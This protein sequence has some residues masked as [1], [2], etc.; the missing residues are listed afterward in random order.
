M[1]DAM[2]PP[3][4]AQ[5]PA[6]PAKK[7]VYP[8]SLRRYL[9]CPHRC[10]LQYVDR[11]PV[12][13]PAWDRV[14]EKGNALHKLMERH[15]WNL[16]KQRQKSINEKLFVGYKLPAMRYPFQEQRDQD[17][18]DVLEWSRRACAYLKEQPTEFLSIEFYKPRVWERSSDPT[19]LGIGAK[20]D[21][22]VKRRD[23]VGPYIE[24][25]DYKTGKNREFTGH[26]PLLSRIALHDLMLR[27]LPNG[28]HPRSIFTYLWL[29]SGET[30]CIDLEREYL[31]EQ[32][33]VVGKQIDD[34]LGERTWPMRPS[35]RCRW[36][37]YFNTACSPDLRGT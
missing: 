35:R 1:G 3:D 19:P 25:I 14:L 32:W 23:S 4:S 6:W 31:L 27:H 10:R 29:E 37:P 33:K 34:L 5:A 7:P 15:A 2:A 26:A 9:E 12:P 21:V 8:T 17:I 13:E 18:R 20:A 11:V 30:Q 28:D 22:V 16:W 24:I 36:C